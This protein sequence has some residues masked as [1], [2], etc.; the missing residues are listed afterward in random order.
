MQTVTLNVS[1]YD[2]ILAEDLHLFAE[3]NATKLF[4]LLEGMERG[5]RR[6][7]HIQDAIS[8]AWGIPDDW[9]KIG[10]LGWDESQASADQK[11]ILRAH[12]EYKS[13]FQDQEH[14]MRTG[15]WI[16]GRK[17]I[18]CF[19]SCLEEFPALRK[20]VIED[21]SRFP[22]SDR[23][24]AFGDHNPFEEKAHMNRCLATSTWKGS[25]RTAPDTSPPAYIVPDLFTALAG[26]SIRPQS[27][28]IRITAPFNLRCMQMTDNQL[29][30]VK[31]TLSK[32]EKLYFWMQ[33]W[34]RKDSL[35]ENNDRPREELKSLYNLTTAFFSST[36]INELHLSLDDYPCFYEFPTISLFDLLPYPL[37]SSNIRKIYFRNVPLKLGELH[38]YVGSLKETLEWFNVYSP[39]LLDGT[40][41]EALNGMK[42]LEK[43]E[44]LELKYMK[45]GE[46]GEATRWVANQPEEEDLVAFVMGRSQKN[47]LEGWVPDNN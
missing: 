20:I 3:H 25:F 29:D 14:L 28:E 16:G 22:F 15:D 24:W 39:Y 13:K 40:W 4:Q 43:L 9:D 32:A 45:G 10:V 42:S 38:T 33:S 34:A 26:T 44:H 17:W 30:A 36:R 1:Y 8:K 31:T 18:E 19:L 23:W 47:P 35:A 21:R 5:Y 2:K 27:F 12:E 7:D 46:Y 11:L 37:P 6:N 41:V